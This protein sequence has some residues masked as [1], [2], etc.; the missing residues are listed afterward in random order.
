MKY[1][2]HSNGGRI[3][4]V[5]IK[6]RDVNLYVNNQNTKSM[7]FLET[8]ES[9]QIFIGKSEK[10]KMTEFSGGYGRKFDGN[11]I[12]LHLHSNQ[13]MFIGDEVYVFTSIGKIKS[14]VS[15]VGNNDVPYPYAIDD[16]D[17]TYLLTE[18]KILKGIYDDPYD[19]YYDNKPSVR[20]LKPKRI[21]TWEFAEKDYDKNKKDYVSY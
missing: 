2:T 19:F 1:F 14:F 8:I 10:N 7:R 17:N 9:E 12:L 5:E 3:F 4:C 20:S 13:Y 15:P 11:S 16:L 21:Y 6:S 18:T